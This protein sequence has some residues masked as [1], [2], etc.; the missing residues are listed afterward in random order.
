MI[1]QKLLK[2]NINNLKRQIQYSC[3]HLC[4]FAQFVR[5]NN[6]EIGLG[7]KIVRESVVV[8][9][10]WSLRLR[11]GKKASRVK[12]SEGSSF[13]SLS[14]SLAYYSDRIEALFLHCGGVFSL[15]ESR[16]RKS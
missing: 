8:Q 16:S 3:F 7:E 4:T 5:V 11:R 6:R 13:F 15:R 14:L 1:S 12:S 2:Q 9:Y 10:Y